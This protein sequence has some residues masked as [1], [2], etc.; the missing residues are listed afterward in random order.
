MAIHKEK[1]E[2]MSVACIVIACMLA[3]FILLAISPF[4][5]TAW[6]TP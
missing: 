5:L 1:R 3:C 4:V 2:G 6:M